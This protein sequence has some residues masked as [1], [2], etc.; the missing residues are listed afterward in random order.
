MLMRKFYAPR[1]FDIETIRSVFKGKS[2]IFQFN[3]ASFSFTILAEEL[4]RYRSFFNSQKI[5]YLSIY[6]KDIMHFSRV[7][8][9][10]SRRIETTLAKSLLLCESS[11]KPV[12]KR[13]FVVLNNEATMT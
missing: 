12:L 6:L 2:K 8:T 4:Y 9:W 5:C 10:L 3:I 13:R 7:L 1:R 11:H